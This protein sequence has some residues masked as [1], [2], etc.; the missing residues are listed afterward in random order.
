M[1]CCCQSRTIFVS[2]A[3]DFPSP[4]L[5]YCLKPIPKKLIPPDSYPPPTFFFFECTVFEFSQSTS[6]FCPHSSVGVLRAF[7]FLSSPQ[8]FFQIISNLLEEENKEKW[9]DA[10]K[11]GTP[12]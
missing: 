9:E 10:Q 11:V 2:P 5:T 7:S 1:V 4:V 6:L 12:L 8:N 3:P